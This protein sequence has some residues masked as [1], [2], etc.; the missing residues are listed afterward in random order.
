MKRFTTILI[1]SFFAFQ[2]NSYAQVYFQETFG[3]TLDDRS[4]SA[5][6]VT[7]GG[8]I[9][10]GYTNSFGAG[11]DDAYIVRLD[12]NGD[13]L[14]T[15]AYGGSSGDEAFYSI[16]QTTDSGFI[17]TG[18]T[19]SFGAGLWDVY[20]IKTDANGDT[21]WT[22]AYGG[23]GYEIGA[24]V[25]QTYDG[26]YII[27]GYTNSFGGTY[28]LYLIRTNATGDTLWT[29]TYGGGNWE[30]GNDVR[31]TS[32]SG[33]IATG[34]SI[35]YG[36]GNYELYLIKTD[37]N[38]DTLWTRTYGESGN[39]EGFSV[40]QTTDNGY[41]ILGI[42][43]NFGVGNPDFY[44]LKLDAGGDTL[45]TKTYGGSLDDYGY[46]VQQ[47]AD[48]GY[49]FAGLTF[50]FGAGVRDAYLVR[51][52]ANGDTLW[53]RAYGGT[54]QDWANSVQ[55]CSDGGFV[56]SV[57]QESFGAGD[58][59]M[60]LLKVDSMGNAGCNQYNTATQVGN[61]ATLMSFG[62]VVGFGATVSNTATVVTSPASQESLLCVTCDSLIANYSYVADTFVVN[63]TDS[64]SGATGWYW[65]FGDGN[66]DTVQNPTNVYAGQGTYLVC[67]TISNP[68][69]ADTICDTIIV[70]PLPFAG[71]SYTDSLLTVSFSDTSTNTTSWYWN[72]GDG[73]NDTVQNP[74]HN[75]TNPGTYFV[76][77]YA[78][79]FCGTDS[80]C[81]SITVTDVGISRYL[82]GGGIHIYPN[83]NSGQFTI[84]VQGSEFKSSIYIYNI[85]GEPVY[86]LTN[87][88]INQLTIDISSLPAGMYMLSVLD[89][90]G[91]PIARQKIIRQ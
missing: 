91:V 68:C 56:L 41:I 2:T 21:L 26:G 32:D 85:L 90:Q 66:N 28:E 51:T 63:F 78:T 22:R 37:A 49:I 52:D 53:T 16:L 54:N 47:T 80:I 46:A 39:D 59:D 71:F 45:W 35:S 67:L 25:Q 57:P 5:V 27:T 89:V 60:M 81:D 84:T 48:G 9:I 7:D 83:P 3:D 50:S 70:C 72:F 82:S 36:A 4:F 74:V 8:Y 40:Q 65:D 11:L 86:Q 61:T 55:Q 29:R 44:V 75:Y 79:N 87:Q 38:G 33:F 10:A 69:G 15:K 73:N 77:L 20:L 64:S 62:G 18:Y 88:P 14:W 58:Y 31:Q 23:G 34:A 24:S 1:V 30:W 43:D 19:S 6:Q 17:A 42:T 76:C 12:V 13:T